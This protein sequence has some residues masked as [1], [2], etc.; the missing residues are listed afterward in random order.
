MLGKRASNRKNADS[1]N[2]KLASSELMEHWNH[3]DD[4][5]KLP[6]GTVHRAKMGPQAPSVPYP[7]P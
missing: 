5:L 3:F 2:F 1:V 7:S 6:W 4:S